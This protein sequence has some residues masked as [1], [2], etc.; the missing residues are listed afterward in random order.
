MNADLLNLL[1]HDG[2]NH[3]YFLIHEP[4]TDVRVLEEADLCIRDIV[5]GNAQENHAAYPT[6]ILNQNGI[7]FLPWQLIKRY[8]SFLPSRHFPYEDA[9]VFCDAIRRLVGWREISYRLDQYIEKQVQERY[10]LERDRPDGSLSYVLRPEVCVENVD[11]ALLRFA[12][13][14]AVSHTVYGPSYETCSTERILGLVSQLHPKM[15]EELKTY[16]SGKLSEDIRTRKTDYFIASVNDAFGTIRIIAKDS[17]EK[18]YSEIL[19]YLC[20]VLEQADFPRSY[21]VEFRGKEKFYLPISGLPRK[22]VHQLFACAVRFP[23]LHSAIERYARLAM[24]QNEQYT[25]LSDEQCALPGSFAVFA[26]GMQGK[27]WWPL[28]WDYLDLC[29][30]EHSRLQEKFLREFVKLFG[31]TVDTAP[32]FIRG[33]LSMQNMKYSKDYAAW[34]VNEESLNALLQAKENLTQIVPSGF[35]IDDEEDDDEEWNQDTESSPEEVLQ[36]AWETVC[37]VIWGKASAKEGE[38]VVEEASDEL[39]KLYQQIFTP[40]TR[41]EKE[42][43]S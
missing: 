11:D 10:F 32:I 26:L 5:E 14:V 18:C 33:V 38:K 12:C 30:D 7:P 28:V 17:S 41:K 29:D 20:S 19:E 2:F 37:Y 15:V 27:E 23:H 8:L 39:K 25:N 16:G 1:K 31:F 36:Y 43:Q 13:Y 4:D 35:C 34:M 42:N 9:V 24:R 6:V 22:G 3:R 40:I 21:S